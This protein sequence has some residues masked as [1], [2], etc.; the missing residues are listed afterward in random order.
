MTT[1]TIRGLDDLTVNA[2][3]EKAKK[4]GSSVNAALVKL[5][6][7]ELGIKKKKRNVVYNDLD[8]LAGTWNDKDYKEFL[9]ATADFAKIDKDAWK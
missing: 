4:E 6:Q 1:M 7:E 8:H 3:K 5:I 2:L 9:K